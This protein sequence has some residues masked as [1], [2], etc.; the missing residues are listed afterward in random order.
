M[1]LFHLTFA[2]A[3][4][5]Q[6]AERKQAVISNRNLGV[7]GHCIGLANYMSAHVD[8]IDWATGLNTDVR[9]SLPCTDGY[10]LMPLRDL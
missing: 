3:V 2:S 9:L 8:N 1:C 4:S 6:L 10:F 5:G 7:L